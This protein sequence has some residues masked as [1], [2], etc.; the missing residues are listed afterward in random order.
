MA[1]R[2]LGQAKEA[3][4]S[5]LRHRVAGRT[6]RV[7]IVTALLALLV[8]PS[9]FAHATL[10]QTT[11]SNDAVLKRAPARVLLRFD[12]AI[13]TV[14]GSV[15]V[16]DGAARRIDDGET[17]R[18]QA[19]EVAVGLP[20]SLAKGTYTVAW[21]VISAD[22]HPVRGAFVFHVGKPGVGGAGVASQVLDAQA[23]SRTVDL[24]FAVVRFVNL[25]LILLSVGGATGLAFV[26]RD[27]GA[28]VRRSLWAFVAAAGVLLAVAS[29]VWIGLE[30]AQ[31]SG[32][33]LGA[34]ARVA[35]IRDVVRTSFGQVWLVRSGLALLLAL[36]AGAAVRRRTYSRSVEFQVLILAVVVAVTPAL[37]GHARVEGA[38]AVVS[39]S[40]HVIS[41]GVWVGGLV[42]L[43]FALVQAGGDRWS[44]ATTAV[45]RF[46]TIAVIAVAVLIVAGVVSGF[47]EVRSWQGL[48]QTTYGQLLLVKVGLLLPLL[49]LGAFNNRILVPRFR[50]GASS[51][52]QRRRFIRSTVAEVV[53]MAVIVG[54]T[55]A[56]VAERPA[57]AQVTANA[58]PVSRDTRTGPFDLNLVVD[59]ARTGNN[60]MHLY[61]LNHSTGQPAQVAE[62]RVS[63]S[64]PAAGIGPLRFTATPAG[65]GH[66]VVTDASFPLSGSWQILVEV[67][68]GD[69][70]QWSTTLNNIQIRRGK[71]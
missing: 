52:R 5:C 17:S 54:V 61:L 28:R 64:L 4:I 46:S 44:L 35:L 62:V 49:A 41:A 32:L 20:R 53:V 19:D 37:S 42:A 29:L 60:E 68:R 47:L 15:R 33:G 39:D 24:A 51:P 45:P 43:L 1:R 70:D 36:V 69:F 7:A 63:A 18:P 31:A 55:A 12:E 50:E 21:R 58:G 26:M 59:P 25:A 2:L 66:V 57:K 65:P 22:S 16:Y 14:L 30:G 3:R 6:L 48:W 56:L 40:L 11:P 34:A 13:A 23:G 38:L 27:A 8:A 10:L 71:P 67:R 9:A